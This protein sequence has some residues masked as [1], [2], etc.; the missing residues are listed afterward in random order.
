M[1]QNYAVE[2]ATCNYKLSAICIRF[3]E[4]IPVLR[5]GSPKAGVWALDSSTAF[6]DYMQHSHESGSV[7]LWNSKKEHEML[8]N[9]ADLF[10][11]LKT[12]EKLERA[13]VRDAV[14][15]KDYE[16]QC[17][18]LI[19]QFKTLWDTLRESVRDIQ[20]FTKEYNLQCPMAL[21]RL[22]YS[23]MPAT[24]EH[25]KPSGGSSA[26]TARLVAETVQYFITAMDAV[27][28][29]MAAVDE[30]YPLLNDLQTAMNQISALPGDFPGKV[31]A[32]A[33]ISRLHQMSAAQEL[34][35]D[36]IRQ[37]LFD[38]ESSYNDFMQQLPNLS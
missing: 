33:W 6:R 12:T 21:Q 9:Y 4:H 19:A 18:K 16:I 35:P 37:L 27:K 38:L 25:G 15:A 2:N 8:E 34:T 30:L 14:T 13:Y 26:N 24:V 28:M 7:R 20:Q 17:S 11:I 36:D 22:V 31:K 5:V 23:G 1:H 3:F 29:K 32:R 10:A